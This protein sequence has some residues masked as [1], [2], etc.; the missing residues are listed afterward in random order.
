[1]MDYYP[2]TLVKTND[3]HPQKNYIFGYHPH[4]AFTEGA[5]IGLNTEACGFNDKFPGIIHI[6]P[7]SQVCSNRFESPHFNVVFG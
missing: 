6:C 7:R 1:M 3:F 2:I 5:A 4:G